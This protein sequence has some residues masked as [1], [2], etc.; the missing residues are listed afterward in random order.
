[1]PAKRVAL[2]SLAKELGVTPYDIVRHCHAESLALPDVTE[3]KRGVTGFM[4]LGTAE[5]IREWHSS[6]A[7]RHVERS[8]NAESERRFASSLIDDAR[9][10][11]VSDAE[12]VLRHM[13]SDMQ[14]MNFNP[15]SQQS[16]RR[17]YLALKEWDQ[18]Y[19]LDLCWE[20]T[21][22]GHQHA[23]ILT[24]RFADAFIDVMIA[25]KR[26]PKFYLCGECGGFPSAR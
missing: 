14:A 16:R 1:M 9:R 22:C 13:V 11:G 25:K 17:L 2:R 18:T 21:R 26:R 15:L 5:T 23:P 7:I 20:C 6:G 4:S 24:K 3:G 12:D 10:R 8:S 19:S